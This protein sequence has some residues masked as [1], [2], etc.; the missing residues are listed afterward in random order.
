MSGLSRRKVDRENLWS[1]AK[2]RK[3]GFE[4]SV[5]STAVFGYKKKEASK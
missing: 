3:N 1:S 2:P 5:V 4:R